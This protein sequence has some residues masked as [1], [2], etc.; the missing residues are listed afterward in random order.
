M[1]NPRPPPL[2]HPCPT[3]LRHPLTVLNRSPYSTA[4]SSMRGA[5]IRQGPHLHGSQCAGISAPA[6][7]HTPALARTHTHT[8]ARTARLPHQP[9]PPI[10]GPTCLPGLHPTHQG[11]QKSSSTGTGLFSTSSSKV[12]SFTAPAPAGSAL[13]LI[14]VPGAALGAGEQGGEPGGVPTLGG[15]QALTSEHP[16]RPRRGLSGPLQPAGRCQGRLEADA[17]SLGGAGHPTAGAGAGGEHKRSHWHVLGD[18][19]WGIGRLG[20]SWAGG[21]VIETG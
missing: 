5:I 19:G 2:P 12:V 17:G 7:R 21:A 1:L 11:A 3:P 13:R 15:A 16:Q 6:A 4:S 10:G 18:A 14:T 20:L 9:V 8:P